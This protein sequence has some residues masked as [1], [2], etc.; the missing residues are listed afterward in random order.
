M[1]QKSAKNSRESSRNKNYSINTFLKKTK[2]V[3]LVL[4]LLVNGF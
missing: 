1:E 3:M 2:N 4:N